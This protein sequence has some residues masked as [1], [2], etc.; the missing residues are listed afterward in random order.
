MINQQKYFL[1]V[2]GG[3]SKCRVLLTNEL[4]EALGEGISGPANPNQGL[5]Q[6]INSIL[7]ATEQALK[8]AD[9]PSHCID[10]IH[11]GVG[12]AG[13]NLP[14]YRRM[15]EQW[16]HPFAQ[17]HIT[18]DLEI[19]C[20]G[21]H[22]GEDGAVIISGTGSVGMV[23]NKGTQHAFGGYGFSVGDQGSGAW[24]GHQAVI[25][26]LLALDGLRPRSELVDKLLSF[27]QCADTQ[28]LAEKM[29]NLPPSAYARLAPLVIAQAESQKDAIALDILMSAA[30]Y[31]N[32]L[33]RKLLSFHPPRLAMIGGLAEPIRSWLA[34]DVKPHIQEA[35]HS[36]EVGAILY[37][38][39][40]SVISENV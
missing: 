7:S 19:A 3:G 2:D 13:V 33:S 36:P 38:K 18:T 24:I 35:I 21:A 23:C 15:L 9:L 22:D 40:K 31:I 17:M 28:Q 8:Q 27:T 34:E 14:K 37:I 10:K 1:G 12:L 5:D 26:C 32:Q 20:L 29:A 25:Q 30:D 6:A 16:D 4:G 11:A 39:Q